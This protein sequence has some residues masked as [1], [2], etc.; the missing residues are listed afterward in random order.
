M[1]LDP[2]DKYLT[3]DVDVESLNDLDEQVTSVEYLADT[4][5]AAGSEH[6]AHFLIKYFEELD[7]RNSNMEV[8]IELTSISKLIDD[9]TIGCLKYIVD[10]HSEQK[11]W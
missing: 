5:H 10:I 11:D 2:D 7:V 1:S 9:N 6:M 4:V 3:L 8:A